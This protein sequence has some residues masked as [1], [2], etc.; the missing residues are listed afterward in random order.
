VTE[1]SVA[2]EKGGK[3]LLVGA[4]FRQRFFDLF[5][6]SLRSSTPK[7]VKVSPN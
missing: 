6:N 5:R 2:A 7:R 1:R 4:Y 3:G